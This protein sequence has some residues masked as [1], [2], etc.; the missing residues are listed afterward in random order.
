MDV[1]QTVKRL[2]KCYKPFQFNTRN[3]MYYIVIILF[4]TLNWIAKNN[5]WTKQTKQT[6]QQKQPNNRQSNAFD[7]K[8]ENRTNSQKNGV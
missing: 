3:P 5:K 6:N 4:A 8:T 2:K 1:K 7:E